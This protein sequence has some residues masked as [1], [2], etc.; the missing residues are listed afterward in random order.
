MA[1]I[2]PPEPG[3]VTP[4]WETVS[5]AGGRQGPALPPAAAS[6]DPDQQRRWIRVTPQGIAVTPAPQA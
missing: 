1:D 2:P 6:E 3:T 5:R 4:G